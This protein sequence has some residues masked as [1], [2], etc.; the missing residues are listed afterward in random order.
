ME[1][2]AGEL[3]PE[4]TSAH[5]LRHTFARSYLAQD[6]MIWWVWRRC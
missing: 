6:R 3:V 1:K 5:L 2:A 4:E